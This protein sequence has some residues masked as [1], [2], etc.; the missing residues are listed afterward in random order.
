MGVVEEGKTILREGRRVDALAFAPGSESVAAVI[1]KG[2][3]VQ[4][5]LAGT[6]MVLFGDWEEMRGSGEELSPLAFSPDGRWLAFGDS[7]TG[8]LILLDTHSPQTY[9]STPVTFLS[10]AD[11]L[12]RAIHDITFS[13]SGDLLAA[14]DSARLGRL[15][16]WT[17]SLWAEVRSFR[18]ATA[19]A[20]SGDG[21]RIA[22][23]GSG[24]AV[25]LYSTDSGAKLGQITVG[26]RSEESVLFL[27]WTPADEA[28]ILATGSDDF[29]GAQGIQ[30]LHRWD[31][32]KRRETH[33]DSFGT[34]SL[35]A[36]SPGGRYLASVSHDE[37][38]SP[39]AIHFWELVAWHEVGWIEWDPE[40]AIHA[41]AFSPDDETL[42]IGTHHGRI[43]L[44]PWR[45]LLVG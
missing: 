35:L 37:L 8:Q 31:L 4:I 12:S 2:A 15:F 21:Q 11:S 26:A 36:M 29:V 18:G 39:S 25:R 7:E 19:I 20:F 10:I 27:A 16:R 45:Q 9:E 14:C 30:R 3:L 33:S 38:H 13:R 32:T 6:E 5:R 28:L 22:V 17:G 41:L 40:D 1:G 44:V 24:G 42:A 43:K 34:P 23:G